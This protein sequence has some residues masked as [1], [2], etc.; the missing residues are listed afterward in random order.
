M[1]EQSNDREARARYLREMNMDIDELDEMLGEMLSHARLDRDKKTI[2][3]TPVLLHDWLREQALRHRRNCNGKT[4]QVSY[5]AGL[6]AQAVKCM[7]PKLMARALSNLIQNGCRYA[8]HSIHIHLEYNTGQYTLSVDDDGPG[9]PTA[10]QDK[11][12]ESFTRVNPSRGRDSGGYGLGLAIVK[13]IA[14]AHQGSVKV[15]RSELGGAKFILSWQG[16]QQ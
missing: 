1:L 3:Y 6:S 9:I 7:D 4:I 12:F 10:V 15:S 14:E 11:I 5:D 13:Q 2:E 16:I 8:E